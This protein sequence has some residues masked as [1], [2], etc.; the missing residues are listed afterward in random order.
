M[1]A[2]FVSS[3]AWPLEASPWRARN[4]PLIVVEDSDEDFDTLVEAAHAAGQ[5]RTI[6]R[7]LS[8][9][10]CIA[11][12]RG[13]SGEP[14]TLPCVL[15]ALI[16]MD[17]NSHGLDGREAL[18]VIKNDPR[19]KKIP[20]VILTTSSNPKDMTFCLNAG[21]N[22]YHVKPVRHDQYLQLLGSVLRYW[23]ESATQGNPTAGAG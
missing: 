11:F 13:E 5:T 19:L 1:P 10:A 9:D 4:A 12:L 22:A 15:P 2:S 8:G 17:L 23:L 3:A 16:F 6:H 14:K 20:L 21:A 18:V 7:A